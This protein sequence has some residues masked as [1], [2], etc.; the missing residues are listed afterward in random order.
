MKNSDHEAAAILDAVARLRA[1]LAVAHGLV[2]SGREVDL[3][4]L[5]GEAARLCAAAACAGPAA[6]PALRDALTAAAREV[7]RLE[8]LMSRA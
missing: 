7:E 2:R 5:D 4:G 1:S 6:H 3:A 8:A